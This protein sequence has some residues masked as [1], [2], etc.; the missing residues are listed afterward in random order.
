MVVA[1]ISVQAGMTLRYAYCT[2]C[3]KPHAAE[4]STMINLSWQVYTFTIGFYALPF[5]NRV[6][7]E[8]SWGVLASINFLLW[9][10]IIFLMWKGEEIRKRQ[11]PIGTRIFDVTSPLFWVALTS[12]MMD[13]Y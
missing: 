3:Y 1:S 12:M 6:G 7:Y 8:M 11:C 10:P 5:S 4:V 2:D 13:L 9:L